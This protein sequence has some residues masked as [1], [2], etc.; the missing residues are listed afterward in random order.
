MQVAGN[1]FGEFDLR[2]ALQREA[3]MDDVVDHVD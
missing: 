2:P 1:V 3:V